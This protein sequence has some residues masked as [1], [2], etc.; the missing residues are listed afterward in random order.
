MKNKKSLKRPRGSEDDESKRL[1][2]YEGG[3]ADTM[4]KKSGK[5][6]KKPVTKYH[7]CCKYSSA[8]T[9]YGI[10][11]WIFGILILCNTLIEFQ[12]K[13]L[14]KWYPIMGVIFALVYV[15]GLILFAA[16]CCKD[17]YGTRTSL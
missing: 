7:C 11:L 17:G 5:K 15:A 4:S 13:Y 12:N 9:V 2:K 16:W 1:L 3:M 6:A 10:L 8:I 14:P